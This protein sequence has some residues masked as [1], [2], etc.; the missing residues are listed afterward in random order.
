MYKKVKLLCVVLDDIYPPHT[1]PHPHPHTLKLKLDR[2]IPVNGTPLSNSDLK[3]MHVFFKKMC[4]HSNSGY[5]RVYCTPGADPGFL[6]GGFI[7]IKVLGF[8]FLILSHVS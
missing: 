4:T 8:F 6:Q 7:S 2:E 3:W 5:Q 1:P